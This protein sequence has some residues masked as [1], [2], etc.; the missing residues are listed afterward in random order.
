MFLFN[1]GGSGGNC[2]ISE[3]IYFIIQ[4][5]FKLL[6]VSTRTSQRR[7]SRGSEQYSYIHLIPGNIACNNQ[8]RKDLNPNYNKHTISL[9]IEICYH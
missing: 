9:V 2:E 4:P 5:Y 1:C 6:G 7:K 8:K 3:N